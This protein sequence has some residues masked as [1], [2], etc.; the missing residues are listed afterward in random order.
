MRVVCQLGAP[1]WDDKWNDLERL[2]HFLGQSHMGGFFAEATRQL[3]FVQLV[4]P[5]AVCEEATGLR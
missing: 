5:S 2:H 1:G 4:W 3:G